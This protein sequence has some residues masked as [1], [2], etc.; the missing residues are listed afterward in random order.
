MPGVPQEIAYAM[1]GCSVVCRLASRREIGGYS[2]QREWEWRGV[3]LWSV[4]LNQ[5]QGRL[6]EEMTLLIRSEVC[7]F[8]ALK[9]ISLHVY[10]NDEGFLKEP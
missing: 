4:C 8:C 6:L 2:A 10:N 9:Q 5:G 1:D 3:G 7:L